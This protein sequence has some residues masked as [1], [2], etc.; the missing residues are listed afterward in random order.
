[1][2]NEELGKHDELIDTFSDM[3]MERVLTN[4]KYL[5]HRTAGSIMLFKC[6]Y[7]KL[8]LNSI[9]LN[10]DYGVG[11]DDPKSIEIL[12]STGQ[13]K[14]GMLSSFQSEKAYKKDRALEIFD[15]TNQGCL[16]VTEEY[17]QGLISLI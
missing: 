13:T 15:L 5:E 8:L 1:M 7:E 4:I 17:Y 9:N 10:G 11:F 6:E 3:V 14:D 2:Q 12:L 16:I